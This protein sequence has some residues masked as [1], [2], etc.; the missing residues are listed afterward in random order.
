MKTLIET[1]AD[2]GEAMRELGRI[3]ASHNAC[4]E[5]KHKDVLMEDKDRV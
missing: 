3:E 4:E 1:I 2:Y 5:G